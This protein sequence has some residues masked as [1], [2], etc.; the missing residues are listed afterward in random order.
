MG[1]LTSRMGVSTTTCG[2]VQNDASWSHHP[3]TEHERCRPVHESADPHEC[4]EATVR[5]RESCSV[6]ACALTLPLRVLGTAGRGAVGPL[7][8]TKVSFSYSTHVQRVARKPNKNRNHAGPLR[9]HAM[10]HAQLHV[11]V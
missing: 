8:S 10:S 11:T 2:H 5:R 9:S 1:M 3:C 4:N 6:A 7:G